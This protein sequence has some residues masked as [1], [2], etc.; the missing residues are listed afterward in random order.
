MNAYAKAY[1][2]LL[3]RD[4]TRAIDGIDDIYIFSVLEIFKDQH[5]SSIKLK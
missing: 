3:A 2:I 1:T 5:T 4:K